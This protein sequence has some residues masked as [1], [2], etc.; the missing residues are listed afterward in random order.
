[1]PAELTEVFNK[2]SIDLIAEKSNTSVRFV[3]QAMGPPIWV[4]ENG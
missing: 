4:S 3:K 1:L 2:Q